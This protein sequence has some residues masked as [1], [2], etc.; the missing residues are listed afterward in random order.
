MR[1]GKV[2]AV[3]PLLLPLPVASEA[4]PP[5]TDTTDLQSKVNDLLAPL[6]ERDIASG[7]VLIAEGDEI[8]M[9]R[10]FGLAN[11][12]HRV[13]NTLRRRDS[14]LLRSASL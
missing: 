7:A 6:V 11:R 8:R 3:L 13:S 5:G 4:S 1:M 9:V 10:G 14:G 12:D 2:L